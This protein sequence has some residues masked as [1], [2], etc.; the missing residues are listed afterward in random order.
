[1]WRFVAFAL[2]L[3]N[4][5]VIAF[6]AVP[7]NVMQLALDTLSEVLALSRLLFVVGITTVLRLN[8]TNFLHAPLQQHAVK[9]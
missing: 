2:L 1:M 5:A 3:Q 6:V 9:H 8:G 7:I 4:S